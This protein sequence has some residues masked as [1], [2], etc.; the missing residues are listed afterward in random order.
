[1]KVTLTT[2]ILKNGLKTVLKE[3]LKNDDLRLEMLK[4]IK[5]KNS[6]YNIMDLD[7]DYKC[8]QTNFGYKVTETIIQNRMTKETEVKQ[9]LYY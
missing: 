4:N 9:F 7:F 5:E 2:T 6:I 1:M 3:N 8:S